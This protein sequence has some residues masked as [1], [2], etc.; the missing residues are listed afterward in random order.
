MF[1]LKIK[2]VKKTINW[3][4]K[5]LPPFTN[6]LDHSLKFPKL[7]GRKELD[8]TKATQP[9]CKHATI[10]GSLNIFQKSSMHVYLCAFFYTLLTFNFT[11]YPGLCIVMPVFGR[12]LLTKS[13]IKKL[14]AVWFQLIRNKSCDICLL[15]TSTTFIK[16]CVVLLELPQ[17]LSGKESA[18]NVGAAGAAGLIPGSGR[19]PEGGNGRLL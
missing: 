2:T 17:W 14:H 19:S 11:L 1:L 7:R 6:Q 9:S 3:K 15:C 10:T 8:T 18:C 12:P 13:G 16:I 4:K 5:I